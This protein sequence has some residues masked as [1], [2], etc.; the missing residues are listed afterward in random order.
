[1]LTRS[2]KRLRHYDGISIPIPTLPNEIFVLIL[3]FSDMITQLAGTFHLIF[4]IV[5]GG[6]YQLPSDNRP[7]LHY[8]MIFYHY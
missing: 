5:Y 2:Q 7:I 3:S 6:V 8:Q 1:M 4:L